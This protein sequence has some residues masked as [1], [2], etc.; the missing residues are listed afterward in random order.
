MTGSLH[1]GI[2]LAMRPAA[3]LAF[4]L[5]FAPL[6]AMG[7]QRV[8]F[9]DGRDLRVRSIEVEGDVAH[10]EL[11][12]GGALTLPL[13][14]VVSVEPVPAARPAEAP[15]LVAPEDSGKA[16]T[17]LALEA[18][19]RGQETWR[20]AAGIY[21]DMLAEAA[22]R[23]GVGRALLAAVAKS[24]SG[25]DPKAVSKKG[26][27]G[28]LQ[29]LPATSR[30]FGVND[31]FDP[32]QNIEGG[33]RYLRWLI[34]RYPGRLDLA[35]AGYNAGEGAVDRHHAVPPYR[36]TLTY[37]VRVLKQAAAGAETGP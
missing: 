25:F 16:A 7:A 30:R 11:E 36:E 37:V 27:Q 35:L 18:E 4:V 19:F 2:Y 31:P 13:A 9:D 17:I 1:A 23:N 24:E 6:A 8:V 20:G 28:L 12:D 33:A 3:L 34:E 21:A 15:P 10:L 29:L 14:S 32:R 26:A 22:D 5:A